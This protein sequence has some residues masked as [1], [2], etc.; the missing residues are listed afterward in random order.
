MHGLVEDTLNPA[1]AVIATAPSLS[2]SRA[3][4]DAESFRDPYRVRE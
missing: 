2:G 3:D 4:E 1:K